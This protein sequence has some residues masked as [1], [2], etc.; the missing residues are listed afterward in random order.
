MKV[1]DKIRGFLIAMYCLGT[2]VHA[3]GDSVHTY[4]FVFT[5]QLQNHWKNK[6]ETTA[7]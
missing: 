5:C 3:S 6:M 7:M 1:Y 2:G 4:I